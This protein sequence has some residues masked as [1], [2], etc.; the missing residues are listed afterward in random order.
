MNV[1]R[2]WF[3]VG[4]L[5][6]MAG[7]GF[8]NEL[9][10]ARIFSDG[11]VLQREIE[12]PVWGTATPGAEVQVSF[13]DQVEKVKA[14]AEGVWMLRLNSLEASEQGRVMTIRSEGTS[15][16][17]KDVLVGEVWLCGGQ[18]NMAWTMRNLRGKKTSEH[19]VNLLVQKEVA[20]AND[21]A[22]RLFAVDVVASPFEESRTVKSKTGWMDVNPKD[23]IKFS[24]V[25]YFFG[26][27]L[28]KELGVPVGLINC[29]R[30]GTKVETWTP[31]EGFEQ[32]TGGTAY[33]EQEREAEQ[34]R[35][36]PT[37]LFNGSINP[38]IPFAMRGVIFYQGESNCGYRSEYYGKTFLA[39]INSW[40]ARWNQDR[41][42]FY[43]CQLA[44]YTDPKQINADRDEWA[45]IRNQ[46]R[47]VLELVPDSGMA[48]LSD[49]GEANNIHPMNKV[50]AGKRLSLWALNRSYGRDL[51]CSGPL[52]KDSRIEGNKMVITFEHAGSGL[53][54]G[55]KDSLDPV[56]EVD[57][58]LKRFQICGAD[59]AW[60]WAE[61][62][63]TGTDTIEVRH[64]DVPEPVEVRYAWSQNPEGANLYNKEGLPAS[65]FKTELK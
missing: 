13:G 36:M 49:I 12:V 48:V 45:E 42:D 60:K 51:V 43:W 64:A 28:R 44:N 26:K 5:M 57:E 14:D 24:G 6:L 11:V 40:R 52:Y 17:I 39:M 34:A 46:Q 10:I 31:A 65:I 37:A 16:E 19:P 41:L 9:A 32:V 54:V 35:M 25:G 58:P 50:D 22:L 56:Q 59:R 21:S 20:A 63:I 62:K 2:I 29:N 61:A 55:K 7:Q 47:E 33:Y 3:W 30:G 18:S 8:A 27:E 1:F 4:F 15:I 53:M 23:I 38:L